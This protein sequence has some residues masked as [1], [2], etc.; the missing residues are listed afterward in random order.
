MNT[1]ACMELEEVLGSYENPFERL[2]RKRLSLSDQPTFGRE[3]QAVADTGWYWDEEMAPAALYS[4][5]EEPDACRVPKREVHYGCVYGPF[6]RG[7]CL[8]CGLRKAGG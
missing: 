5:Q 6:F 8:K 3:P 1:D 4:V 2:M 7:Y